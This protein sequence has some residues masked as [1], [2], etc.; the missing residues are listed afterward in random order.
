VS[1]RTDISIDWNASPRIITVAAPSTEF[2]AQD[3]VDTLRFEESRVWNAQYRKLLTAAGKEEL[4]GGTE[5]GVT[6]TLQNSVVA[7]EARKTSTSE[8]TATAQDTTGVT[9]TDSAADFV[10]DSVVAGAW[11]VNLTDSSVC[12]VLEVVDLN[13][14]RTDG[15]GDGIDNQFDIGDSYSII[16]VIGCDL[17]GGNVLAVDSG[18]A[19]ISPVLPTAGTQVRLTA[20][21][22]ATTQNQ[23][24]LEHSSFNGV[25]TFDQANG[26]PGSIGLAGSP[27]QPVNNVP[28]MRIIA[29]A[30][31]FSKIQII[32]DA[33]FDT[34][35]DISGFIIYG[36][37]PSKTLLTFNAGALT[38]G[39]DVND[40]TVT[41]TFDT[42]ASFT[43]C[44]L[45][46]ISFVKSIIN[47]CVLNGP[48]TLAGTGTTII[49]NSSDG[50]VNTAPPPSVDFDGSGRSLAIRNYHGDIQLKNKSGSE[51]IEVNINSGGLI[52][53]DDTITAGVIRLSGLLHVQDLTGP[54]VT[55]DVSDVIYP[56]QQQLSAFVD[57]V[58]L[59]VVGGTAGIKYPQGTSQY[60]V[61]NLADALTILN[62]RNLDELH[63]IGDLT[64]GATDNIDGLRIVGQHRNR[65]TL[66]LVAGCSTMDSYISHCTLT[67]VVNGSIVVQSSVVYGLLNVGSEAKSS[68]F[69][70][71]SPISDGG[72]AI[73]FR[74]DLANP[75]PVY[76]LQCFSGEIGH[77]PAVIDMNDSLQTFTVQSWSG[78][79][80]FKNWSQGQVCSVDADSGHAIPDSSCTSGTLILHG[81][82]VVTNN[83]TGAFVVDQ[84][85][86]VGAGGAEGIAASVWG[87][88]FAG[89]LSAQQSVEQAALEAKIGRQILRNNITWDPGT[90]VMTIYDD[91]DTTILFK[92]L[93]TDATA[94]PS[95]ANPLNREKVP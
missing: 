44:H 3:I 76:V 38:S 40:A 67:G 30:R 15:L 82:I 10:A 58:H 35:D 55:V 75:M 47:R 21:S 95:V 83:S 45:E 43:D 74:N 63:V 88:S 73:T 56:E 11:L 92:S 51:R 27:T 20:S 66:T 72:S 37:N 54:G 77:M 31:G 57:A 85:E 60:P 94:T 29:T 33:T 86:A 89:G 5:V 48:I 93:F 26:T 25:V 65:T 28:D 41:G 50:L 52:V 68:F 9:L 62:E 81:T 53:L 39:I 19:F 12:T 32:G 1:I 46:T 36:E 2:N 78:G 64:I 59:D 13:T 24:Q 91:D 70:D 23:A 4:G 16:N 7:F 42:S 71:T 69:L 84:S 8:G 17:S 6:I 61:D 79:I 87:T 18:G 90:A 80:G 34:G 49:T 22:A 14:L